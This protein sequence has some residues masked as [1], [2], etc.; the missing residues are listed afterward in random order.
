MKFVSAAKAAYDFYMQESYGYL[1]YADWDNLSD[2]SKR[3]WIG[4]VKTAIKAYEIENR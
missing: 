2:D 3:L 1:S 4:L